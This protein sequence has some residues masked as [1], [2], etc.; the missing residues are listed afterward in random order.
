MNGT[1][2]EKSRISVIQNLKNLLL[3]QQKNI[4]DYLILLKNEKTAIVEADLDKIALYTELEGR[5]NTAITSGNK[6]L[7]SWD[8]KYQ[9]EVTPPDDEIERLKGGL[10]DL[11]RNALK[12][13]LENKALLNEKLKGIKKEMNALPFRNYIVSSPYKKIGNP[14]FIDISS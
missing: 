13:N 7:V 1:P 3:H 11:R 4:R 8:L 10:E 12:I 6:A 5:H 9:K 2:R 14:K